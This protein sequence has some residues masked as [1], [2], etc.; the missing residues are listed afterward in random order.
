MLFGV[1]TAL[2]CV[3]CSLPV[4]KE[5]S[6]PRL[7]YTSTINVVFNGKPIED[8]DEA[9][10]SPVPPDMVSKKNKISCS[11]TNNLQWQTRFYQYHHY[12]C[13]VFFVY[14]WSH[15]KNPNNETFSDIKRATNA[16]TACFC[17]LQH[18]DHYSRTKA[19]AEQMVLSANGCCLKGAKRSVC[20]VMAYNHMV[21]WKGRLQWEKIATSDFCFC[22]KNVWNSTERQRL[23]RWLPWKLGVPSNTTAIWV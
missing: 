21:T 14:H 2:F 19:I 13:H 4:C 15:D 3:I 12:K 11:S 20:A 8:G 16:S 7:V 18:I 17:L 10:V 9:S 22:V 1:T 23:K 5:R 6:I